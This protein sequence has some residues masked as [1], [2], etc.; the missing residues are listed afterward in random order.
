MI[1]WALIIGM[2]ITQDVSNALK[3]GAMVTESF[4]TKVACEQGKATMEKEA[5][6]SM[7]AGTTP[8][9]VNSVGVVCVPVD[10]NIHNKKA[11]GKNA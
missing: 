4:S 1:V 3:S 11:K 7:E 6:E 9:E 10:L 2:S 8:N 5:K